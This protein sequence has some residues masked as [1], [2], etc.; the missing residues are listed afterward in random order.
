VVALDILHK[1]FAEDEVV[2]VKMNPV[3][4]YLGSLLAQ[5]FSPLV[6]LGVLSFVY[7]GKEVGAYL[8]HHDLVGTCHLTGSEATYNAIVWGAPDAPVRARG[9]G[10]GGG[11]AREFTWSYQ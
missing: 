4:D 1:L 6:E 10:G 8:T 3:N 7:G 11:T 5:A 2:L 9:A